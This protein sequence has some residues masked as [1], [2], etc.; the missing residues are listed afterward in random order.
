MTPHRVNRAHW[1]T[2]GNEK[3]LYFLHVIG[4]WKNCSWVASNEAGSFCFSPTN[5][6]I[7]DILGD[8]YLDFQRLYFLLFLDDPRFPDFQVPGFPDSQAGEGGDNQSLDLAGSPPQ[9]QIW[10]IR[11]TG[12]RLWEPHQCKPCLGNKM[13]RAWSERNIMRTMLSECCKSKPRNAPNRNNDILIKPVE[14]G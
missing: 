3:N 14:A 7:A 5:P 4:P 1:S 8:T 12:A 11:G 10:E 13:P 6:D 9:D 2:K